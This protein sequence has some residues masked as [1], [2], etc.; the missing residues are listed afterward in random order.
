MPTYKYDKNKD[1]Q[2]LINQAV[3]SGDLHSAATYEQQRNTKIQAEGSPYQQTNNYSNYLPQEYNGTQYYNDVDYKAQMDKAA[4][5]GDWNSVTQYEKQRNA[6][7]QAQGLPYQQT[8]YGYTPQY[9]DRINELLGKLTNRKA[10]SYDAGSDPVYQQYRQQYMAQGKQA[11]QDTMGQA[12]A[13]TGGYGS[14]YAQQVGQQQYDNYLSRLNDILPQLENT[15]YNRYNDELSDLQSQY[16][17]YRNLDDAAYQR[18]QNNRSEYAAY[19]QQQVA[20]EEAA[21]QQAANEADT[22]FKMGGTPSDELLAKTGYSKEYTDALKKYYAQLAAQQASSNSGSGRSGRSSGGG[23][24]NT[25]YPADRNYYVDKSG[26][27]H[28]KHV[29][30]LNYD[31]D[32]GTFSWNYDP[33]KSGDKQKHTYSSISELVEA[34]NKADLTDADEAYIRQ[35]FK[36]LTGK[37]L[38]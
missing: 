23:G 8:S 19:I 2:A 37:S 10:F 34:M 15:A 32:E 20:A 4:R 26:E 21:K 6:K 5:Q 14:S 24:G 12:A 38:P 27:T 35:K 30:L 17:L 31:P 25:R 29:R 16:S 13:L 18:A 11:M 3:A 36:S 9:D 22:I 7:I 28:Y 33:S 1:Y